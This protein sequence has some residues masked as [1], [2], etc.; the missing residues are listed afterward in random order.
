MISSFLD[1]SASFFIF[2]TFVTGYLS[3]NQLVISEI[4]TGE[5][6]NFLFLFIA[7]ESTIYNDMNITCDTVYG[8]KTV[9][10]STRSIWSGRRNLVQV[11]NNTSST[12][13]RGDVNDSLSMSLNLTS[14]SDE[15]LLSTLPSWCSFQGM[16]RCCADSWCRKYIENLYSIIYC[17]IRFDMFLYF[18]I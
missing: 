15:G 14:S 18:T 16:I 5:C 6:S 10:T 9:W 1:E 8:T 2:V 3:S 17:L 7:F 12:I 11:D 4:T 13:D